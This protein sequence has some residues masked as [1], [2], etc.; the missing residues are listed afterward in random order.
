MEFVR[1]KGSQKET[2]PMALPFFLFNIVNRFLHPRPSLNNEEL[3][4]LGSQP[5]SQA[6]ETK[7]LQPTKT[8]GWNP[9]IG[10]L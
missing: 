8:N 9:K 1:D 6:S 10:D 5:G 2:T 7:G 4:R 3:I